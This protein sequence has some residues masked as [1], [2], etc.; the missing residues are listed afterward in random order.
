L[1]EPTL[2]GAFIDFKDKV[3]RLILGLKGHA[4]VYPQDTR[5]LL[6]I[7]PLPPSLTKL[8]NTLSVRTQRVHDAL[9]WLC[10]NNEDYRN[11]TVDHAE[12]ARWPAVYIAEDLLTTMGHISNNISEQIDRAG[13]ADDKIDSF[14][15]CD[16]IITS[17]GILDTNDISQSANAITLWQL[18]SLLDEDNIKVV[19]GSN[20]MSSWNNTAYFT[21]AFPSLFPYGT[22]K[23]KDPRRSKQLSLKEWA[24]LLLRHCSR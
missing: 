14:D 8:W 17:S 5:A 22:G 13:S 20:L 12:F 21:S 1:L 23:H 9:L 16:D 7:L 10:Y 18:A 19:H 24:C 2:L 15:V 11:V 4:V 3:M 6:N